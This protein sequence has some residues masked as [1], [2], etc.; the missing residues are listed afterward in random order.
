MGR[1][2]SSSVRSL[3]FFFNRSIYSH[4]SLVLAVSY[5]I[6]IH[7]VQSDGWLRMRLTFDSLV[8][9]IFRILT[10]Q[11]G[12]N[13]CLGE[14]LI[15]TFRTLDLIRQFVRRSV[16]RSGVVRSGSVR[17]MFDIRCSTFSM[18]DVFDVRRFRCSTFSMFDIIDVRR[19]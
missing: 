19:D 10:G 16:V 1:F 5:I 2:G 11:A 3:S 17:S 9:V 12:S 15:L 6:K 13:R 8:V 14:N 7:W 4:T 18:F